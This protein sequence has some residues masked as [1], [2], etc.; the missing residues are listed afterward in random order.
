MTQCIPPAKATELRVPRLIDATLRE[1]MQA[2]GVMFN[3]RQSIEIA[4]FLAEVG[5]DMIECGHPAISDHERRRVRAVIQ[6]VPK[7]PIMA[8]ARADTGDIDAVASTG[9][10]W[11]GIFLGVDSRTLD[12]RV[13][14]WTLDFALD[15]IR[16]AVVHARAHDLQVRMTVED[17]SRADFETA[18]KAYRI[19]VASGAQRICYADTVG[20]LEPSQVAERIVA[21]REAF[22]DIGIEVHFHDDRGLALANTLAALRA[23][24]DWASTSVNGL[25]ER[26]GITD[27]AALIANL[28]LAGL[29]ESINSE[30]LQLLS[31]R[32]AAYA[33]SPVDARRPVVGRDVFTHVSRLHRRA[34]EK[35]PGSY[36][37]IDPAVLG[38]I[39]RL[40]PA[41]CSLDPAKLV[42]PVSIRSHSSAGLTAC[43]CSLDR[44]A[45]P[46]GGAFRANITMVEQEAGPL[47]EASELCMSSSDSFLTLIGA[48]PGLKGL[49]ADVR[50]GDENFSVESPTTILFPA[51]VSHAYRIR[52]GAGSVIHHVLSGGELDGE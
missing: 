45:A 43:G 4:T 52:N 22:P 36:Q 44:A 1:G 51:G 10:D 37:W 49:E 14:N 33:R 6:A 50:I 21:L 46:P 28:V 15:R 41:S 30:R 25:G 24:A 19:A 12:A 29:R 47:D 9:C 23:G 39:H 48:R 7:L 16:E 34:M 8:H 27:T 2:A 5:V 13:S 18:L 35:D 17:T 26:A 40:E 3:H 20:V 31:Q 32:V 38:R 11:I 42:A